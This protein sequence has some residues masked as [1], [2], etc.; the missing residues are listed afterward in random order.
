VRDKDI[1]QEMA[2]KS[3]GEHSCFDN[4]FSMKICEE[5][6]EPRTTT[7]KQRLRTIRELSEAE[8]TCRCDVRSDDTGLNE[9]EMQKIMK[10]AK[11]NGATFSAY[12]FHSFERRYQIYVS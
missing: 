9:H 10:A 11:E 3:L 1:L 5:Q 7:A 8:C 6:M 12:T 2:K 4:V